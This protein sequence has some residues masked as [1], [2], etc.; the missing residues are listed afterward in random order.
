MTFRQHVWKFSK[1][2]S[3]NDKQIIPNSVKMVI[4]ID[5]QYKL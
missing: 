2:V 1:S 3:V 4:Y 5:L